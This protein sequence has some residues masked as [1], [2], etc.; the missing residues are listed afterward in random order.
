MQTQYG[1]VIV[2]ITVGISLYR[3][4]LVVLSSISSNADTLQKMRTSETEG[5]RYG[6]FYARPMDAEGGG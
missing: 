1:I 6:R 4:T 5:R 2:V 3:P